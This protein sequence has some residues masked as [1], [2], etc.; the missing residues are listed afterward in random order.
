MGHSAEAIQECTEVLNHID[1][2]DLDALL[3]RGEAFIV[4]EEYEKG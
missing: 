4:H 3:D 1:K 2:N